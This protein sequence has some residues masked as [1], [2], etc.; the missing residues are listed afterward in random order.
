MTENL[1]RL[2]EATSEGYIYLAAL[3]ENDIYKIAFGRI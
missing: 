2:F 1:Y 3:A